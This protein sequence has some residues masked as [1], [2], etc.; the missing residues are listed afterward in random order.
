MDRFSLCCYNICSGPKLPITQLSIITNSQNAWKETNSLLNLG[1]IGTELKKKKIQEKNSKSIDRSYHLFIRV[2]S[3][4]CALNGSKK[5]RVRTSS[6]W[7]IGSH[8]SEADGPRLKAWM[9]RQFQRL[10]SFYCTKRIHCLIRRI[11]N[12]RNARVTE[13]YEKA[14]KCRLRREESH[15]WQSRNITTLKLFDESDSHLV[16]R[17]SLPEE[18]IHDI[19][20]HQHVYTL[21][22]FLHCWIFKHTMRDDWI[23][24][25]RRDA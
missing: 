12:S 14:L 17:N 7:S 22:T 1:S 19:H 23:Q 6:Q 8:A 9:L 20:L 11:N 21:D 18:S 13:M 24:S 4:P 16:S 25:C 2:F 3:L 15:E 5:I 10:F